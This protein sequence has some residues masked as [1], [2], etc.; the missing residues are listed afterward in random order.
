MLAS[1]VSWGSFGLQYCVVLWG[2]FGL[3]YFVV[4][5]GSFGLQYCVNGCV[6]NVLLLYLDILYKLQKWVCRTVGPSLAASLKPLVQCRK[7][8]SW[9]WNRLNWFH[10][11][12]LMACPLIILISWMIFLSP[13]L[14][15]KRMSIPIVSFLAQLDSGILCL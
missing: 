12:I 15:V 9:Y 8:A 4:L 2:S 10:F 3:Q 13:F 1:F 6:E 5:W 11:L 14:D 7:V